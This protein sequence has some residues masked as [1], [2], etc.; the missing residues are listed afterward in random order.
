MRLW[1]TLY[2]SDV[3]VFLYYTSN[4]DYYSIVSETMSGPLRLMF[5]AI[6]PD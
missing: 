3:V 2:D 1:D 4:Y 6:W 5:L